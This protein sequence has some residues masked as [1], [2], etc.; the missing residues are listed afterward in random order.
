MA[1]VSRDPDAVDRQ[2]GIHV[3]AKDIRTSQA[4]DPEK[5]VAV[6]GKTSKGA[7]RSC[8]RDLARKRVQPGQCLIVGVHDEDVV[9][10]DRDL[11]RCAADGNDVYDCVR[12]RVD[13]YQ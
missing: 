13:L 3:D 11:A 12:A 9:A 7:H 6:A 5:A 4:R 1:E 8:G 2:E 10:D